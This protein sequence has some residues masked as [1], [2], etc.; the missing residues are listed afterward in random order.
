VLYLARKRSGLTL[1]EIGHELGI[2]E[3]KTVSRAVQ[4]FEA[5]LPGDRS[6]RRMVK[7]CL[8][9]LSQVET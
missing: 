9:E 4:R 5:S 1:K 2:R 6:K 8:Y 7:E 3:Y